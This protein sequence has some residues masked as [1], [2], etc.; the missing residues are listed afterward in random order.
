M[1]AGG[2]QDLGTVDKECEIVKS[3]VSMQFMMMVVYT[4]LHVFLHDSK[5]TQN[6]EF[7]CL[8]KLSWTK[9]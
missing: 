7:D 8:K 3:F 1:A 9:R 6:N 2:L 5:F 4:I